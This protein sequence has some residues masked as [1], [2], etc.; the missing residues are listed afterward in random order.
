MAEYL[1]ANGY[2]FTFKLATPNVYHLTPAQINA[3]KDRNNFFTTDQK[4]IDVS[5]DLIEATCM[6]TIRNR[7]ISYNSY[8]A[9][10]QIIPSSYTQ[11]DWLLTSGHNARID[12]GV[13]GDDVTLQM[14]GAFMPISL[15]NSYTGVIGNYKTETDTY[16]W[17]IINYANT[18][19]YFN[20]RFYINMG[21]HAA[22]GT[23]GGSSGAA[24]C[25]TNSVINHK[26]TF[27]MSY[28][29]CTMTGTQTQTFT[30]TTLN[31]GVNTTNIAIGASRP[32]ATGGTTQYRLYEFKFYSQRKLIRYYKPCVR[33]SDN[34]AGFYDVVNQ[35]F[36]PSIGS[37][38][39][40][41]GYDT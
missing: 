10:S 11:C 14:K 4:D 17:R 1:L 30:H 33:N 24:P 5:Y 25:G 20:Q 12:T 27:D 18:S 37:V 3:F 39:F 8:I 21:N 6:K 9:S 35:T 23:N 26:I 38:Q 31:T 41:A 40:V 32:S 34:I 15:V 19:S 36:N 22:S 28:G 13:S 2:E 7:V 29:K 16:C